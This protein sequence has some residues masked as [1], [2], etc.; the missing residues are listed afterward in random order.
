MQAQL[1]RSRR[2]TLSV[3]VQADGTVLVRAPLLMPRSEI[4]RFLEKHADWIARQLRI[5]EAAAALRACQLILPLS[6][7]G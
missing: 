3:Q 7:C 2:K 6:A 4:E 1:I 5:R